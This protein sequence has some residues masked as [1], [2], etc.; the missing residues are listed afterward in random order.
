LF[1]FSFSSNALNK[2]KRRKR[3]DINSE[4]Q[5]ERGKVAGLQLMETGLFFV[6]FATL[7]QQ[8]GFNPSLLLLNPIVW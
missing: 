3:T 5:K 1:F 7:F 8:L 6:G 4:K 2:K